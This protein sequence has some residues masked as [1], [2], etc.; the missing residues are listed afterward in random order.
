[1]KR[2][3]LNFTTND[4]RVDSFI[5][6]AVGGAQATLLALARGVAVAAVLSGAQSLGGVV[7]RATA[8]LAAAAA[9]SAFISHVAAI[10]V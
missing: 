6:S 1:M 9:F 4:Y 8:L 3:A 2:I 10:A 7:W 5:S